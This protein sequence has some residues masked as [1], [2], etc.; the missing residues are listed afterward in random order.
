MIV[1]MSEIQ[2]NSVN[3]RRVLLQ[4]PIWSS[5]D[6]Y[7]T[8]P[9]RL[10]STAKW[11]IKLCCAFMLKLWHLYKASSA[12]DT[13]KDMHRTMNQIRCLL[14]VLCLCTDW[15][16]AR[17]KAIVGEPDMYQGQ[18]LFTFSLTY[19][20]TYTYLLAVQEKIRFQSVCM[21]LSGV[22]V[23]LSLVNVKHT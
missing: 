14:A 8:L 16:L 19:S 10:E 23:V 12:G 13:H 17:V 20:H 21:L 18:L 9:L 7:Q 2:Q 22:S 1:G 4:Y 15:P 6:I 3:C 5:V 11:Q